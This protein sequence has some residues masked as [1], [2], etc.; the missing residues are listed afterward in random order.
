[1]EAVAKPAQLIEMFDRVGIDRAVMLPLVTPEN[2]LL[3]QSN[4]EILAI[5]DD[6]PDRFIPFCNIDPDR[7]YVLNGAWACSH[8]TPC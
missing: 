7:S 5:A 4:E 8:P 3:V 2:A 1:M 6:Y